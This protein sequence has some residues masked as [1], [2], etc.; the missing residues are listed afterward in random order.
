MIQTKSIRIGL[1]V[2][3]KIAQLFHFQLNLLLLERI[4][5]DQN[6]EWR[7]E[8]VIQQLSICKRII[9]WDNCEPKNSPPLE[10]IQLYIQF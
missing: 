6:R 10:R 4:E 8:D 9:V 5:R 7:K 1:L 2:M 3:H